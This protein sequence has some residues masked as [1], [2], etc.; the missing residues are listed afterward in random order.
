MSMVS[1]IRSGTISPTLH[2][3]PPTGPSKQPG[4]MSIV[5]FGLAVPHELELAAPV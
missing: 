3:K 4:G 5:G 1:D 2:F